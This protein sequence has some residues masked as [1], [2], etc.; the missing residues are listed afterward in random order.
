MKKSLLIVLL[1]LCLVLAGCGSSKKDAS[2][3]KEPESSVEE[4]SESSVEESSE[5][6]SVEESSKEESSEE[7][8]SV[9]E[10]SE[11]ES[12]EEVSEE[13]SEEESAQESSE[14]ESSGERTNPMYEEFAQEEPE[15]ALV[16]LFNE[17]D[18]EV[19]YAV[20]ISDQFNVAAFDQIII[21]PKYEHMSLTLW[22]LKTEM[23]E[24]GE[25]EKPVQVHD[26]VLYE[27]SDTTD[28]T[29]LYTS[30]ERVEDAPHYALEVKSEHGN[31]EYVFTFNADGNPEYEYITA[32]KEEEKTEK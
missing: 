21:L 29:A 25:E 31:A 16:L 30:I 1:A 13:S 22:S 20:A 28:R 2:E 23:Q 17:P 3:S 14:E 7:E 24:D 26:E 4:S 19:L 10:S 27:I 11:E 9:Q 12:S 32:E 5:E 8:S 15:D 18:G 6:S